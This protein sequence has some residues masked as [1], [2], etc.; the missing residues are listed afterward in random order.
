MGA[1]HAWVS[2]SA[3][4]KP[5]VRH[6]TRTPRW[7]GGQRQVVKGLLTRDCWG[8][9]SGATA[10]RNPPPLSCRNAIPGRVELRGFEP[11]ASCMPSQL[12]Q[13]TGPYGASPDTTSPQVGWEV[14]GLAVL[15]CVGSHGPVADTLL[16]TD[17]CRTHHLTAPWRT[18]APVTYRCCAPCACA[19][20]SWNGAHCGYLTG[21]PAALQAMIRPPRWDCG[22]RGLGGPVPAPSR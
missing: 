13:Q 3:E 22:D 9:T 20:R 19:T 10:A 5:L 1:G 11:L 12:H 4:V 17:R 8:Q 7:Q 14:T 15:S 18:R 21:A 6:E 2:P 16:T